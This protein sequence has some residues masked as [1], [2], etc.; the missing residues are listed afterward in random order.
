MLLEMKG[1][2]NV[3]RYSQW[4]KFENLSLISY[5]GS[6]QNSVSGCGHQQVLI[7]ETV[8]SATVAIGEEDDEKEPL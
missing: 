2:N 3:F 1:E 8:V 7:M 5:L 4:R 6:A